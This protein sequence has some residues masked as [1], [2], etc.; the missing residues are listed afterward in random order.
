VLKRITDN[1]VADLKGLTFGPPVT[2]AYNPLIYAR[3]AWDLYCEKF[4]QGRRE[5]LLLGMNPGP[6]GLSNPCEAA[7]AVSSGPL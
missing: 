5:V 3:E 2:H 1:L 4:G 7:A 6:P